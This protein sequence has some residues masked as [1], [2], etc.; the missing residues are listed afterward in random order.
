[1]IINSL[2]E[3]NE[4][5]LKLAIESGHDWELNDDGEIDF[6]AYQNGDHN[7]PRCKKCG[8]FYCEHCIDP[9]PCLIKE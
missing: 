2:K 4:H 9:E 6:W 7:G 5:N 3:Y 8:Y 1:M